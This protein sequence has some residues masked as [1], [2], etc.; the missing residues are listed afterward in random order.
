MSNKVVDYKLVQTWCYNIDDEISLLLKEGW[1]PL[2]GV[3]VNSDYVSQAMVKYEDELNKKKIEPSF[4]VSNDKKDFA[5]Q[6]YFS[7]PLL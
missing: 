1:Q 4:Q 6:K 3:S 2:G 5:N 7:M